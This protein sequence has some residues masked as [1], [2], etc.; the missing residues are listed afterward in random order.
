[1]PNTEATLIEPDPQLGLD[2]VLYCSHGRRV[3][4]GSGSM[5]AVM[6]MRASSYG[7]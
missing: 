6:R 7:R 3:A 4:L 2:G 5:S 1:M